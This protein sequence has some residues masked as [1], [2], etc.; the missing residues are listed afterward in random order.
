MKKTTLPFWPHIYQ[1]FIED[2]SFFQIKKDVNNYINQNFSQFKH[3]WDCPTLSTIGIS[4]EK[5][6]KSLTLNQEI[7]NHTELYFKSWGFKE[8]PTF[9][10]LQ[11]VWVN[12]SPPL[13]YQETHH[14]Q[15]VLFSGVLYI[16]VN[17]GS[18]DFNI[19]NPLN[20]ECALTPTCKILRNEYVIPPQNKSI[21]LFPGWLNHRVSQNKT[22]TNRISVS[23]NIHAKFP[24]EGGM[25]A[26]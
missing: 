14:H 15:D 3:A 2:D 17:K 20:S 22:N 18:G 26:Y 1:N 10:E 5:S 25:T 6:I 12:F 8:K 11:E 7:K 4:Y 24:T 19:L 9:L 16:D 13:S 21:I 23:F